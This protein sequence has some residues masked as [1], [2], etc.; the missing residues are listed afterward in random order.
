M[1]RR[2]EILVGDENR[3]PVGV[4]GKKLTGFGLTSK[5]EKGEIVS[6]KKHVRKGLGGG[7]ASRALKKQRKLTQPKEFSFATEERLGPAKL[8]IYSPPPKDTTDEDLIKAAAKVHKEGEMTTPLDFHFAT[9]ERITTEAPATDF[10]P[11]VNQVSE[12]WSENKKEEE[13]AEKTTLQGTTKGQF[14]K[15]RNKGM[16]EERPQVEEFEPSV[17]QVQKFWNTL[18]RPDTEPSEARN[19]GA[20]TGTAFA[21]C[22]IPKP[23]RLTHDGEKR[24]LSELSTDERIALELQQKRMAKAKKIRARKI[25]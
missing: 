18:K 6:A 14:P 7:N 2:S 25:R 21:T 17:I 9:D 22:T 1:P 13:D 23:L 8:R 5:V 12:F 15:L 20:K 3:A 19:S 11:L 10:V 16:L 24:L 4:R